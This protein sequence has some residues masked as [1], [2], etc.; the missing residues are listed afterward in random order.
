M[1]PFEVPPGGDMEL[2]SYE[3]PEFT[4]D[5]YINRVKVSMRPGS[6]HFILYTFTNDIPT[7]LVPDEGEIRSL[8]DA[9]VESIYGNL[10]F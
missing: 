5:V 4:E 10:Y 6:H 3:N 8:Y 7:Y 2:L 9:N 1:G